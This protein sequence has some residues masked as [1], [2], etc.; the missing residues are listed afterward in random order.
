M[1]AWLGDALAMFEELE[2]EAGIAEAT[3][4]AAFGIGLMK[5]YEEAIDM[6]LASKALFEKRGDR[7]AVADCLFG[8]AVMYRLVGDFETARDTG[9][10]A[11]AIHREFGDLFGIVSSL[12][13]VGSSA[14]SLGDVDIGRASFM[15]SLAI[16]EALGE[17]TGIALSLDNLANVE[18]T[19]GNLVRALRLAGAA[20]AIKEG[21]GGQAPPDL[22]TLDPR[23]RVRP[24]LSDREIQALWE[25]GRAMSMEEAIAYAR[26]EPR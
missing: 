6:L 14:T 2:D 26:E 21:V 24:Q 19:A 8:L 15:E 10:E 20:D 11:L 18:I 22:I 23:E 1:S 25:E 9:K 7:R 13:A 12:Y 16:D 17:R 5:R 4:N 3:Y